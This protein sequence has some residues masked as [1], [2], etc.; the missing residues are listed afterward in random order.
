[1]ART[2]SD[3]AMLLGALTGFDPRDPATESSRGQY[4]SDYSQFLDLQ[5][6]RGARIGVARKFFRSVPADKLLEDA[7]QEMKRQGATVIDPIEDPGLTRFG[8]AERTVLLYEFKNGLNRYLASLGGRAPI[9]SLADVIEFNE[10]NRDKELVYFGQETMLKA[11]EK[12]PLTD[13][14]YLDAVAKCQRLSRAE[15]IDAAMQRHQL[16]AIIAPAGGPAA[17]TDHVNGDRGIGGS[18]SAAAVAGYPNI[19]VPVGFFFGLPVGISFFGRAYSE[20]KLIKLAYAFEQATRQRRAPR[21][22]ASID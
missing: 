12:G 14:E 3:A 1:M 20:P 22:L 9:R 17:K 11:Q 19:T 4:F 5:G 16:D 15:G 21:F 6:L 13:K 7:I 2:V 8:D 10:R 18:S